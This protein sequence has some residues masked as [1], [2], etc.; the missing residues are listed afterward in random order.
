MTAWERNGHVTLHTRV[1]Y[2]FRAPPENKCRFNGAW[3]RGSHQAAAKWLQKIKTS[4]VRKIL[5]EMAFV[6]Q[7]TP[8]GEK[9]DDDFMVYYRMS[10]GNGEEA[11]FV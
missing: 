9:N 6:A 4:V 3:R 11:S 2:T 8:R 5:A 1:S 10:T 7:Q